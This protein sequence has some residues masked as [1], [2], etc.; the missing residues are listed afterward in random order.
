VDEAGKSGNVEGDGVR[1]YVDMVKLWPR[2][3]GW[4]YPQVTGAH[5]VW[6]AI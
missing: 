3:V 4:L 1:E 2:V 5:A 6:L